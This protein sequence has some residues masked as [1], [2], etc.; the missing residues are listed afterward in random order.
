MYVDKDF[1]LIPISDDIYY[2]YKYKIIIIFVATLNYNIY[3]IFLYALLVLCFI[4][5]L[6]T[7][8]HNGKELIYQSTTII[9]TTNIK[10]C[11][12]SLKLNEN[13]MSLL[14]AFIIYRDINSSLMV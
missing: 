13:V 4:I 10:G 6:S 11:K 14:Y 8:T 2:I 12:Y 1:M 7:H 3:S 9:L 5:S